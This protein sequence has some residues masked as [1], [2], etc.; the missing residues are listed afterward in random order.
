MQKT[1]SIS[2]KET[3]YWKLKHCVPFLNSNIWYRKN[4]HYS[5]Y[6]NA[7]LLNI[8]GPDMYYI[9]IT[10]I[11]FGIRL[12]SRNSQTASTNVDL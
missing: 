10:Y 11:V 8:R 6:S 5:E 9:Y 4:R 3:I 2:N 7:D 1:N 12:E